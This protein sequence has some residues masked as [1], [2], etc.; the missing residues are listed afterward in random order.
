M[1]GENT[2]QIVQLRDP[3]MLPAPKQADSQ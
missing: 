3:M 1:N 2:K